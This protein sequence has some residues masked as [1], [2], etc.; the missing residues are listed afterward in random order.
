MLPF[1]LIYLDATRLAKEGQPLPGLGTTTVSSSDIDFRR[2]VV[3]DALLAVLFGLALSCAPASKAAA[4]GSTPTASD[5]ATW[6]PSTGGTVTVSTTVS[7]PGSVVSPAAPE[8]SPESQGPATPEPTPSAEPQGP[9]TPEPSA[10]PQGPATPEPSAEP[11]GPATP[12]LTPSAESQ[13]PATPEP[14]PEPQGPATPE[15]TPSAESQGP[16]TPEPTPRADPQS[17]GTPE[18]TSSAIPQ[19]ALATSPT[20]TDVASLVTQTE[21]ASPPAARAVRPSPRRPVTPSAVDPRRAA[22]SPL[23]FALPPYEDVSSLPALAPSAS[24]RGPAAA[25]IHPMKRRRAEGAD[26]ERGPHS[27]LGPLDGT[28]HAASSATSGGGAAP[29]LYWCTIL[30]GL[31]ACRPQALR[32]HRV[33]Q[34]ARRLVGV[35][36]LHEQ[37]G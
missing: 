30:L 35:A 36:S 8:P 32:R 31:A 20:E 16:A 22:A 26:D 5:T 1:T 3:R 14:S 28:V 37:P 24:S 4:V 27:P 9:A 34:V 13:G 15:P 7:G 11:Q 19:T 18:P 21:A 29:D 6:A 17:P 25:A 12:E 33:R 23:P 10:E 2:R